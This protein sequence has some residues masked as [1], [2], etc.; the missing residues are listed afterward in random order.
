MSDPFAAAQRIADAVLYEGYLL[1]PYHASSSKNRVRFQFGV[2]VPRAHGEID[3]SET[4]HQQTEL[5]VAPS[6][7]G[8]PHAD[9]P[10]VTIRIR[11]LQLQAR[12]VEAADPDAAGGFR[13]V[14]L[15]AVGD[16]EIVA[17]EEAIEGAVDIAGV[18][19][20]DLIA[21]GDAGRPVP[22]AIDGGQD[23]DA[24]ADPAG[25][26][27]GRIVRTRW[28]ID[29][30][31]LLTATPVDGFIRLS[32]R[33]ENLTPPIAAAIAGAPAASRDEALR[34]SLL[35]CHTLLSVAGGSF[36]SQT[37]PPAAAAAAAAACR[38]IK[39]WPVLVGEEGSSDLVVSSPII[40]SDYPAVAPE[41]PRDLFDG[42]EIDEILTLRIMTLSDEEKRQAR[43]TDPR[44]RAIIDA[45]DDMPPEILDRLHGAIRYLR[46]GPAGRA[47]GG[48]PE[49]AADVPY[50]P[51][52][53]TADLEFPTLS[54]PQTDGQ[55][56]TS[57]W[58]PQAR[59]APELMT[60]TVGNREISKG[61]SVR[62][63]PV[64]RADAM[65]TFLIGRLATVEAIFE[66]VDDEQFVAVTI[67][68]DPGNDL[69]RASGRYFYFSPDELEVVDASV[70]TAATGAAR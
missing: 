13:A 17:W 18:S 12:A 51:F 54:T 27:T 41:S 47:V 70:E 39:V 55:L 50:V 60:A 69:H 32:V 62:L 5:L 22:F 53:P 38:N 64:R 23:I 7:A 66:S 34:R 49:S 44:A 42:A 63:V 2:V 40:L 31:I 9:D 52:D 16:D 43:A 46:G 6:G 59:V 29:G 65:D 67:D 4:W 37:D 36:I 33:V 28:P 56:P 8:A 48:S 61:S 24:V 19:L 21:S 26:P 1:Y 11:F 68:D 57:V 10:R 58:E 3:P 25:T 30:R 45:A 20:A 15:L 14:P 35:G